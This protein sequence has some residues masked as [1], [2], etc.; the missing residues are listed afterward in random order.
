MPNRKADES[1]LWQWLKKAE[2]GFGTILHLERIENSCAKGTPDVLGCLSSVSF[3]IEL[4]AVERPKSK[5]TTIDIG[6]SVDQIWWAKRRFDAGGRD[7]WVL[8]QVGSGTDAKRY[9]IKGIFAD[10]FEKRK[11]EADIESYAFV[12]RTSI[13]TLNHIY[14]CG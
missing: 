9:L 7:H 1:S 4:K 11:T 14:R 3:T 6:L 12:C 13:E 2:S 5:A 8:V 10:C